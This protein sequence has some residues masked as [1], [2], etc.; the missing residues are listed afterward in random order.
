[1]EEQ[2][3]EQKTQRYHPWLIWSIAAVLTLILVTVC[4]IIGAG[5][6]EKI[7]EETEIVEETEPT[8]PPSPFAEN[9]YGPEDFQLEESYLTCV[10]GQS[11]LGIDVSS[12]QG[13]IDWNAVADAGVKFAMIRVG[14]RGYGAAGVLF[15]DEWAQINYEGAK[16]AGLQV[17]CYFFSQATCVEEALEEAAF[18]L[19][20]IKGWELD[21]PV[22]FDWEYL[23]QGTRTV[24]VDRRTATDCTLMFCKT[25]EF[26]GYEAMTY[27]NINQ[28]ENHVYMEELTEYRGWLAM[29]S[30]QM[31][32]PYKVDMWQYTDNGSVPGIEGPVDIDLYFSY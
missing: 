26:M 15:A 7:P 31:T 9:P 1:M 27:F 2:L 18:T 24:N 3:L 23:G 19:L 6:R 25:V 11:A 32:Y 17:G 20:Q 10:A 5:V 8:Q 14:G 21:L 30:D 16:A 29:Y 28:A 22:V 4:L 12:H 13:E